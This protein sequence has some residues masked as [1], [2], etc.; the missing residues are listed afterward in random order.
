MSKVGLERVKSVERRRGASL[1]AGPP[2]SACV[3]AGGRTAAT[4]HAIQSGAACGVHRAV[5]MASRGRVRP[6]RRGRA[7]GRAGGP[8]LQS[9][10]H[11][12]TNNHT[13]TQSRNRG[14]LTED[15]IRLLVSERPL[16]GRQARRGP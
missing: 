11:S 3:S 10:N 16:D 7:D 5:R 14:P 2:I 8:Q 12:R 1:R 4:A 6:A 9:N 13:I 15:P